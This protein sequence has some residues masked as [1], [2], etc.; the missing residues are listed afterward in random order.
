MRHE[1]FPH[2][3][4]PILVGRLSASVAFSLALV[5]CSGSPTGGEGD[6]PGQEDPLP[7]PAAVVDLRITEVTPTTV[8]LAWTVPV[9][10]A[11]HGYVEGYDI[12]YTATEPQDEGAWNTATQLE[13]E[14]GPAPGGSEQSWTVTDL[15]YGNSY[16]FA[17]KC[18]GE[19]ESP[20]WSGISNVADATLP[21]DFLVQVPD[22]ALESVLREA[23]EKP[24]G[25]LM[26]SDL[27]TLTEVEAS[28][29]HVA[30]LTGLENCENLT[31]LRATDNLLTD[32][33]PLAGLTHLGGLD[34]IANQIQDVTP[35]ADLSALFHLH[36]GQNEI[37]DIAPLANLTGLTVFRAHYNSIQDIS[38]LGSF[39]LLEWL[40]LRGNQ[41]QDITPL[42]NNAGLGAGD[43]VQ[44]E[45]NP[46]S[47]AAID[48]D[49][50]ALR[51]RGVDV[52]F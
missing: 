43:L 1:I 15:Q 38:I 25:D 21:V 20:L 40:D 4:H 3:V 26:Y 28:D 2:G 11:S 36:I 12:R 42:V 39:N 16:Y 5:S 24:S 31:L 49:I 23:L 27:L 14:P 18:R 17:M 46:L 6:D 37:D 41:I 30:Q 19:G 47:Q 10:D 45:G 8:T 34:L 51:A 33:T 7:A 52:R 50:A 9:R 29:R 48:N 35:L 32:L 13:G 22:T 44:L